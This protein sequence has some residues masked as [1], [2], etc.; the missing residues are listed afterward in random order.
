MDPVALIPTPDTIPVHWGW[1]QFLLLL[2]FYLHILFMNVMLGTI[3][4]AFVRHFQRPTETCPLTEEISQ[5][6]PFS[7]ALAVNFGVAPLLFVQ[8]LYGHFIYASSI[9]M[10]VLWLSIVG[11]L[12]AA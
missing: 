9:L 10:A 11:I 5:K 7:I 8:V 1:F 12:I 6:L 3:I 2:T 4:I